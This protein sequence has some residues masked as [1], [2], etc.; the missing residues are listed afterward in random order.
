MV[1]DVEVLEHAHNRVVR[2]VFE[3]V[4][5]SVELD[6]VVFVVHPD[7]GV[8]LAEAKL[9]VLI[10]DP[11]VVP[12]HEERQVPLVHV[13]DAC[14][15]G[16]ERDFLCVLRHR[17][18]VG[19][20]SIV[21]PKR[22][23]VLLVLRVAVAVLVLVGYADHDLLGGVV[24]GADLDLEDILGLV[25]AIIDHGDQALHV[26]LF[27]L[28]KDFQLGA[29]LDLDVGS[30]LVLVHGYVDWYEVGVEKD[31]PQKLSGNAYVVFHNLN[32]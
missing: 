24:V 27:F 7:C 18:V 29:A 21:A 22:E 30:F 11:L 10:G 15:G 5:K 3:D 17:S 20:L 28:L 31:A 32:W 23:R 13:E 12:I 19:L 25:V 16:T 8:V 6:Y 9:A 14:H 26:L 1:D 4:V 2:F